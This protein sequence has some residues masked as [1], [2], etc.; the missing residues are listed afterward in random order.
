MGY[1]T[2]F[3]FILL[4]VFHC[5]CLAQIQTSVSFRPEK[6]SVE[7]IL[8]VANNKYINF[9]ELKENNSH[10]PSVES[11]YQT[12][13]HLIWIATIDE[14]LIEYNGTSFVHYRTSRND[15]FSIA[16][17][18]VNKIFEEDALTLWVS[19]ITAICKFDRQTKRFSPL[20]LEGKL[21]GGY[22]FLK[23]PNGK[24]L[25]ATN[26]GLCIINT[27]ENKLAAF[28][29]QRIKNNR[30]V[31]YL[32]ESIK[33]LGSL[34]YDD[35]HHI[36]C[37]IKTQNMEGLASF[38]LFSHEWTFYPQNEMNLQESESING[39]PDI[40]TTYDICA[41]P[42]GERIWAGGFATGL[43]CLYKSTG[44]WKTFFFE[45]KKYPDYVNAI[46]SISVKNKNE[47]WIGTYTGMEHFSTDTYKTTTFL[48][49][50]NM[51]NNAPPITVHHL[52]TDHLGNL[53]IG[54]DLG[55]FRLHALNN[56][57]TGDE[58]LDGSD[59]NITATLQLDNG[60]FFI[61]NDTKNGE[62]EKNNEV[63]EYN[64]LERKVKYN[65]PLMNYL[66]I[67]PIRK[68]DFAKKGRLITFSGDGIMVA[69]TFTKRF[70]PLPITLLSENAKIPNF[71]CDFSSVVRWN[72]SV[73][74]GCR[75]TTATLG[76]VEINLNT[77]VAKQ[78]KL[79]PLMNQYQPIS[80]SIHFLYKDL[81]NRLWCCSDD[82]GLSIFYPS[83]QFFEH[84]FTIP[85]NSSS[86][87]S[88][89]IR[90]VYQTSDSIFWVATN[91]GLCKT[92]AVPGTKAKFEVIIPDVECNFI[93]ED[94]KGHLW[95][96]SK[97]GNYKLERKTG[98][99]QFFGK[100]DGYYWETYSGKKFLMPDG[101]FL[102][103]D[104]HFMN[105]SLITSNQY[106]PV[107][108]VTS[109]DIFNNPYRSDTAFP[110]KKVLYLEHLQNFL[111]IHY[112]CDSYIN[113]NK[114]TYYYKLD[115]IDTGWVYADRRTTAYYT[116]VP[117]GKYYFYV[118]AV[119]NDGLSG[120]SK[121]LLSIII[122]PAWYQT[123]WFKLLCLIT[124]ISIV[125]F[126][127]QQRIQKEKAKGLAKSSE[128]RLKQLSAEFEKQIAETEMV[129]LRAQ[130]NPHFIFN[131]LN[132]INKYILVNDGE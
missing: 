127:Y 91:A 28:P 86:L 78:Y 62:G 20:H 124:A 9:S 8:P 59:F 42:D 107:P 114:N 1:C 131:V 33:E 32:N 97:K 55:V 95:I 22:G 64:G 70:T 54:S 94:G 111:S 16:S 25:C 23:L 104:G 3:L 57:F 51:F 53:W 116:Q 72:D 119:N 66:L 71:L 102:M 82:R 87:P 74:Y 122:I 45:T 36:W 123:G 26:E 63:I 31:Y 27:K 40:M 60:N 103:P 47:L 89:L 14:G 41:D 130:M 15:S 88:N 101:Q 129:A 76:F 50:D 21:V 108:L 96:N 83:R 46:N 84:Y 128:A 67:N 49:G 18:R 120:E 12:K 93:F 10:L 30:G 115:G 37:N 99:W 75:R 7:H 113:E 44:L 34:F 4:H 17:N 85:D 2:T 13:D 126:F 35:D 109:I 106:K 117:P 58:T 6:K 11:I 132:S 79:G 39:K 38:D 81:Y 90:S 43:R 65:Y 73:Y 105:P 77:Q 121:K 52:L 100:E 56:K 92:P 125:Y 48:D 110:L 118:K 80:N 5:T 24:T 112:S 19:T 61:G 98:K 29:N 69:D 68:I